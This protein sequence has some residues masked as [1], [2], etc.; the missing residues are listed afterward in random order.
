[1]WARFAPAD[2][3]DEV[4]FHPQHLLIYFREAD[5]VF[6]IMLLTQ[7]KGPIRPHASK[8]K[9]EDDK[10]APPPIENTPLGGTG[11]ELGQPAPGR[12]GG[13]AQPGANWQVGDKFVGFTMDL[14]DLPPHLDWGPD[15]QQNHF[16][17]YVPA[18]WDVGVAE[19][20]PGQIGAIGSQGAGRGRA[21]GPAEKKGGSPGLAE[22]APQLAS[23]MGVA[24]A[25]E[26]PTAPPE[27]AA[28]QR[29]D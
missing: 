27:V 13:Q 10:L 21:A 7:G 4:Y 9:V 18:E 1:M 11:E 25:P 22:E 2:L 16:V 23:S 8:I 6:R 28:V 17:V 5:I 12:A 3:S 14:P 15:G 29:M 24:R 20:D 19:P 26:P